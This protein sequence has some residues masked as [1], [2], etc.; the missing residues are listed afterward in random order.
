MDINSRLFS[1]QHCEKCNGKLNRKRS[2]PTETIVQ[3]I[4]ILIMVTALSGFAYSGNIIGIIAFLIFTIILGYIF[5]KFEST[6]IC[7][8]CK[9]SYKNGRLIDENNQA[10]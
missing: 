4:V 7:N 5:D 1:Y 10:T 6:F 8:D 3:T 2:N 9:I